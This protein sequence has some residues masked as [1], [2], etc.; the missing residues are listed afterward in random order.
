MNN[1]A[2]AKIAEAEH[3]RKGKEPGFGTAMIAVGVMISCAAV[4]TGLIFLLMLA[5]GPTEVRKPAAD[6]SSPI[7]EPQSPAQN[8][9]GV[10]K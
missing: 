9:P 1:A 3:E 7:A 6:R 2:K 5:I 4:L 10:V 8:A